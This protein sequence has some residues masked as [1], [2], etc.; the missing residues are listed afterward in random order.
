MF[1]ST[2]ALRVDV[3]FVRVYS[4]CVQAVH[5]RV[6]GLELSLGAG[7]LQMDQDQQGEEETTQQLWYSPRLCATL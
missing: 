4:M 7:E 3:N 2:C 6:L 1:F 5:C